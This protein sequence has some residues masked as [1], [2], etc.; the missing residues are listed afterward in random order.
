MSHKFITAEEFKLWSRIDSD[1]EDS[2]IE[3]L[4]ESASSIVLS[5]IKKPELIGWKLY[6]SNTMPK[7]IKI[8]TCLVA[9]R[10]YEDRETGNPLSEAVIN[11]LRPL[12]DPALS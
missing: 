11:I 7:Q 3:M 12:R 5:H 9:A 4:I 2:I 8:A 6:D 1:S 10:L